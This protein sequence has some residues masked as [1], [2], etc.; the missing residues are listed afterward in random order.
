[1]YAAVEDPYCWP[2][3]T[4]LRNRAR[5]Q[6][7]ALLDAFE[8]DMTTQRASEIL[9]RG[10]LGTRHYLAIHRHLFGDVY[11]WAGKRRTVRISK[12]GSSFAYPEYIDREMERLFGWLRERRH[13][14]GLP[15]VDFVRDAAHFLAELNAIHPF[16]EGNGRT[17]LTFLALIAAQAGH[18]LHLERL[19]PEAI[20]Q[21]TIES[22]HGSNEALIAVLTDLV[23]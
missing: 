5:L 18:P 21:A 19:K 13:L 2:G 16:R 15:A 20:L 12:E 7:Q 10:S 1:M 14:R 23:A 3:T 17:S 22:F 4:V 11:T 6:D 8:L 9:P